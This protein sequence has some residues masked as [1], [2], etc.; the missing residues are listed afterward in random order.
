M[1]LYL[2][3]R[4]LAFAFLRIIARHGEHCPV[5]FF[6]SSSQIVNDAGLHPFSMIVFV[7]S[8]IFLNG[9]EI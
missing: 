1:S 9:S 4:F 8:I 6:V 2:Y 3:A 5:L 7:V